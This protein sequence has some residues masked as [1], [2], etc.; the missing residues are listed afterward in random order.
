MMAMRNK[1]T[2]R[3][4]Q[5]G[6]TLIELLVVITIIGILAAF[7]IPVVKGVMR[8]SYISHASAEMNQLETAIQNYHDALGFYPPE[9][10]GNPLTNQLY[11]ELVGTTNTSAAGVTPIVFRTLDGASQID[12]GQLVSA[13]GNV[14]GFVNCSKP[15]A[16]GEDSAGA[17]NFI[18]ELKPGQIGTINANGISITS[19]VTSIGGPD[20]DYQPVGEPNV[21]PWRYHYPGT[22]NP[23][24]YDLWI[25]LKISGQT[26]LLCN[27]KKQASP[28]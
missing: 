11:Y 7:T 14:S 3:K 8:R 1:I 28:D 24:G 21:N 17:K 4:S 18:H 20:S 9:N 16:G 5:T 19:F 2:N 13:F 25:Q 26:N 22:Y 27:W 6:F 15:G 12:S 23:N 10:P